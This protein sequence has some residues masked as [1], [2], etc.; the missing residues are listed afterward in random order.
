MEVNTSLLRNFYMVFLKFYL[1]LLFSLSDFIFIDFLKLC[2]LITANNLKF[3]C[4]YKLMPFLKLGQGKF[5][6]HV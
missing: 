2:T 1:R 4:F 6:L 3:L 5:E